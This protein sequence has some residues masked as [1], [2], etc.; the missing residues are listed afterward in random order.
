VFDV[1]GHFVIR[2]ANVKNGKKQPKAQT[3]S[4]KTA[5]LETS[6]GSASGSCAGRFGTL[7]RF[8]GYCGDDA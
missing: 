5:N 3:E 7:G 6:N 8:K 4:E 1:L 2:F